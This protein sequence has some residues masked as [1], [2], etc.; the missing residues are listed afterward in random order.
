MVPMP[1]GARAHTLLCPVMSAGLTVRHN[2]V[3]L[4][5]LSYFLNPR[6]CG[7]HFHCIVL[8]ICEPTSRAFPFLLP[9]S[10]QIVT[11][12]GAPDPSRGRISRK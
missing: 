12:N 7:E 11:D 5:I 6:G 4:Y 3:E 9:L 8:H 2:N 10:S 1:N